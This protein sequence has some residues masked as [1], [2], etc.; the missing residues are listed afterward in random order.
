MEN[1][2]NGDYDQKGRNP[3]NAQSQNQGQQSQ[4]Y[5]S[6]SNPGEDEA[7][8]ATGNTNGESGAVSSDSFTSPNRYEHDGSES[9][10]AEESN[11][12]RLSSDSA[13]LDNETE[14]FDSN[15][16]SNEEQRTPGL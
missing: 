13:Q 7:K 8:N 16:E 6:Q 10:T 11:D 2:T 9:G 5:D 14:A 15:D 3:Q 4:S 12:Q 1:Q